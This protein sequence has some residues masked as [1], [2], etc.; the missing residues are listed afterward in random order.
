M[1]MN[2]W[3][4]LNIQASVSWGVFPGFPHSYVVIAVS[5]KARCSEK[6]SSVPVD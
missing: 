6:I 3:L 4:S 1:H 5:M 2:V